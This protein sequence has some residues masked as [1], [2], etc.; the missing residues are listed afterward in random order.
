MPAEIQ[1]YQANQFLQRQGVLFPYA[2]QTLDEIVFPSDN[3]AGI[4]T[5]DLMMQADEIVEPV[6]GWNTLPLRK[7]F[8]GTYF[9]YTSDKRLETLWNNPDLPLSRNPDVIV[10]PNF[11]IQYRFPPIAAGYEI[12]RKRW[13]AR[14]WQ[15]HGVKIIVDLNVAPKYRY[16]NLAGVP[17][18]WRIYAT[19]CI[20]NNLDWLNEEYE[21]AKEHAGCKP[22]FIVYGGQP[23]REIHRRCRKKGWIH[24]ADWTSTIGKP[25]RIHQISS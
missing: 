13:L 10:E 23:G 25:E 24:V 16:W 21:I 1:L 5:L 14:Y 22:I 19:R 3:L 11:S 8:P 2:P 20:R 18:G 12:F 6:I 9:N 15:M 4:P 7:Q 17:K